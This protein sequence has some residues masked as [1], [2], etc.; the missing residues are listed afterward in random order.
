MGELEGVQAVL[1]EVALEPITVFTPIIGA[2]GRLIDLEFYDAN[3]AACAYNAMP[4]EGL[5]GRRLLD[6]F[7][8]ISD[9]SSMETYRH[10][11]DTG[12]TVHLQAQAY[13]SELHGGD[14]RLYDIR[15][16]KIGD[17]LYS[18]WLDVTERAIALR[19]A[20]RS[21]R[22]LEAAE[23]LAHLGSWVWDLSA[24]R[25]WWS[26]EH[27]RI[28]GLNPRQPLPGTDGFAQFVHPD[29]RQH[30]T[31]LLQAT[32]TTHEPY[33][34][35]HRIVRPDGEVRWVRAQG[36]FLPAV[37]G[38]PDRILGVVLDI[39]EQRHYEEEINRLAVTDAL[40]GV[41]NRRHGQQTLAAD[42][43]E[44][45]RYG[46]PLS[47]LMLD[48]DHF[49]AINDTH[50]HQA[51]DLVLVDLCRRLTAN[52]RPSDMLVRWGGEEFVILA[53]H[54]DLDAAIALAEKVHALISSAVFDEVGAVTVSIGVT[55]LRPDDTLDR[56]L[57]RADRALYEAK[58]AGR[59][60]VRSSR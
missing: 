23:R 40:T 36:T 27:Y 20:E 46:P 4:R 43:A 18:A 28:F 8:A 19:D 54:C 49:K 2:D 17:R 44:A 56:W 47:L 6:L 39:T 14:E 58:A 9:S 50:G 41:W 11:L 1:V 60:T 3:P 53:R 37:D 15:I 5:I 52:L 59:N 29:D 35:E 32:Q 55:A 57:D 34:A 33:L 42:L 7:P 22:V 51:G 38:L 24:G 26:D 16:G 48:I 31:E 45:R 13:P 10:V 12:E 30:V 21:N 25:I